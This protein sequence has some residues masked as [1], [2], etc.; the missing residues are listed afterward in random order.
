VKGF[1]AEEIEASLSQQKQI[2]AMVLRRENLKLKSLQF[3]S[4]L[5]R[6]KLSLYN[7]SY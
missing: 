4:S 2:I 3:E 5:F 6:K 7:V 1:A